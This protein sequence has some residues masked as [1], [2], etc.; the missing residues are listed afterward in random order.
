MK[1]PKINLWVIFALVA[2]VGVVYI[3]F[4]SIQQHSYS[5]QELNFSTSGIITVDNP[6]GETLTISAVSPQ[7]FTLAT[8]DPEQQTIR[9]TREGTGRNVLYLAQTEITTNALELD[10]T[11]GTSVDFTI[12]NSSGS[13]LDAV[14]APRPANENRD[15]VLFAIAVC[16]GLLVFISFQTEHYLFKQTISR[17]PLVGQRGKDMEQ[18]PA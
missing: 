18:A 13:L 8:N 10:V 9:A 2:I 16:V 6:S 5:G 14:V 1:V 11:R 15:I 4:N 12:V 7:T 3:T 17:L